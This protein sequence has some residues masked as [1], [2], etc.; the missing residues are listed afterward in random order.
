MDRFKAR[1]VAKGYTQQ[2]GIDFH[3]TPVAKIVTV[4]CLLTVAAKLNWPLHQMDVTNAFLQGDLDEEVYLVLSQ[5]YEVEGE[6]KV[7]K[8]LK[9]LYGLRQASRQWNHKFASIMLKT[10]FHQSKHDHS[11][12]VKKDG[13]NVTVLIVYVDDIIITGNHTDSIVALK[14]HLHAEIQV[15]DL[16]SLKYFLGIEVARSRKGIYLNQRKYA[17]ELIAETGL[18]GSKPFDTP[19]GQNLKL[20]TVE[21]DTA[22][23]PKQL[24]DALLP[25]AALYKRL[26]GRLIY[27]T[28]TRPDICYAVQVLSQFMHSPKVSHMEAAVR[29]VRYLKQ[30]PGQGILLS[31]DGTL[32]LQ[33]YC[34]SDWAS[35]PMSRRSVTGD[36]IMLGD[37]LI[38]WKTKKQN[39]VSRSSA[40]AEYRAMAST[41]CEITWIVGLLKDMGVEHSSPCILFCDNK[42]ALDIAANPLYHE[43][44]KHIEIDC[45]L[46]REKIQQG[47]IITSH[48]SSCQRLADVLTKALGKGQHTYLLRKLGTLNLYQA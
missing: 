9:S 2:Y 29:V 3:D 27:L 41:T 18:S 1:L 15:K 37:S 33:A 22:F 46:I 43:R 20:T 17:L 14:T 26:V 25:D 44:T 39:T 45:H 23:P 47:L 38:S 34:D 11:L 12:F 4:R 6:N 5:G 32:K 10:G 42:A 19:M 13:H 48:I 35:C 21:Y 31:S 40:E 30:S 36:C 24:E 16:G 8:L 28:I 7:C